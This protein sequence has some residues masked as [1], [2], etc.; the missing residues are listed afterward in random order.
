MDKKKKQI[1]EIAGDF[2]SACPP[3]KGNFQYTVKVI[4]EVE[5]WSITDPLYDEVG[6]SLRGV[7]EI[8]DTA[9]MQSLSGPDPMEFRWF[10]DALNRQYYE[11]VKTQE[12]ELGCI[13]DMSISVKRSYHED[14]YRPY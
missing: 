2:W 4:L 11:K 10:C 6:Y 12:Y 5:N 9:L 3:E 8:L 14:G 7:I 1:V 13:V